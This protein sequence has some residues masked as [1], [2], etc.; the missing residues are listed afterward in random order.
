MKVNIGKMNDGKKLEYIIWESLIKSKGV[1]I[2]VHGMAE[3][4]LRYKEFAKKI[5]LNGYHVLGYNQRGHGSRVENLK[6]LG[7][8]GLDGWN[9]AIDDIRVMVKIAKE[10]FP[11]LPVYIFGHSM[12][13]FISRGYLKEYSKEINGLICS[14]TGDDSGILGKIMLLL[15]KINNKTKP[16]VLVNKIIN[17]N[18]NKKIKNKRTEFDWLSTDNIEVDKY[19]KDELCGTLF[20]NNFYVYLFTNVIDVNK[21]LTIDLINK[22]LPIFL[23]SGAEDPVGNYSKGVIKVYEKMKK[24]FIKDVTIK[25]YPN[26]RHEILNEVNKEDVI[27]DII[28]WLDIHT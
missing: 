24:T 13:S 14:G 2:I 26:D 11:N 18:M 12:G 27:N 3:H 6:D 23:L 5:S 19:I 17:S 21:Q 16:A 22:E 20:P 15:S 25:L 10:K 7:D 4:I 8:L 9:L 1:V 28:K